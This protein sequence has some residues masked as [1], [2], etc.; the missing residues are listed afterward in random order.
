MNLLPGDKVDKKYIIHWKS[1]ITGV[2]GQGTDSFP[3][4]LVSQWVEKMNLEYTDIIHWME[5]A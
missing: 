1:K 4:E 5:E 3:W 2:E